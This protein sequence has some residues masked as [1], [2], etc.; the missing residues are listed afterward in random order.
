V[1]EMT[2]PDPVFAYVVRAFPNRPEVDVAET[3]WTRDELDARIDY[4]TRRLSA[5]MDWHEE[6]A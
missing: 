3:P 1:S 2:L 6:N 4:W 5:A